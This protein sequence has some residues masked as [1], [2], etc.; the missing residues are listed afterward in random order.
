[1]I[2]RQS[3][4]ALV[5]GVVT[6]I[7]IVLS[8]FALNGCADIDNKIDS[9]AVENTQQLTGLQ[10]KDLAPEP[11][12]GIVKLNDANNNKIARG[13]DFMAVTANPYATAAAYAV[14][15]NGGTA[16]DATVA[17]QAVLG[18]VEPQSSGLGG[19]GFMLYWDASRKTLQTFDGRETA[20]LA[21]DQN[22]FFDP[23]SQTPDRFFTAVIGGK[24]VGV[25]GIVKLLG[26]AHQLHGRAQW[27]SLFD[28]AI[29]L[30]ENGFEVSPRLN[31]LLR[32]VPKVSERD[33]IADY[34]FAANG[35]PL[36]VGYRLKNPEYADTLK[37]LASQGSAVFYQGALATAMIATSNNDQNPGQLSQRDFDQYQ[38]VQRAAV[39]KNLFDYRVCGM[40]PPS[41]GGSTTLAILGILAQLEKSHALN[42]NSAD[43]D[44][45]QRDIATAHYYIEASRLAFADRNTYI[46]DPDF[47]DVPIDG[48]LD[49]NYMRSRA[50]LITADKV[51]TDVAP[52]KPAGLHTSYT[53]QSSPELMSTTHLS[54]VDR[55]GN[56][57]SMTS[58]IETAFGSRLMTGGFILNNQLTD[59]SFAPRDANQAL[60]ANRVEGGKRPRSS[61]SPMIVFDRNDKPVLIIGSPGGK[62]IIGYVARTLFEVLAFD[63]PLMDAIASPHVF[64]MGSRLEVESTIDESFV[65]AL[66]AYG[67]QPVKK[68]Q[69]SGLHAIML[70]DDGWLGVADPRREGTA[71][72]R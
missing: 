35:D 60:I 57:V 37:Q 58:S 47:V 27:S 63:R 24:S 26:G 30:A 19:G 43:F 3:I 6:P 7:V 55:Y 14:L 23:S 56:A 49:D 10:G 5:F 28:D 36:P 17:A 38:V 44:S 42:F 1:M 71:Q 53:I 65:Q 12:S 41:S 52:G 50:K 11:G 46:A 13:Q 66:Q 64:H 68:P 16:V 67:H 31:I 4:R 70:Q 21:A 20:P 39:C 22:L 18:L 32:L 34:L 62:K 9:S 25:P 8:G 40:G 29:A 48:L 45:L 2:L 59:F 72:G 33:A 61:M 69:T 54:I 51:M 15:D